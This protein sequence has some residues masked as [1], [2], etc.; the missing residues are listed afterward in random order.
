[1]SEREFWIR[2]LALRYGSAK[3]ARYMLDSQEAGADVLPGIQRLVWLHYDNHCVVSAGILLEQLEQAK[4]IPFLVLPRLVRIPQYLDAL[5]KGETIKG[6]TPVDFLAARVRDA[7]KAVSLARLANN[8][9]INRKSEAGRVLT[10]TE[11][12]LLVAKFYHHKMQAAAAKATGDKG[13]FKALLAISLDDYRNLTNL[14][15]TTYESLSDV[16]AWYPVRFKPDICP[17]HW[18]DILP[19]LEREQAQLW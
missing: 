2:R 1:K 15:R 12:V 8:V 7:E 5:R 6:E 14:T 18:T 16:P 4:G 9:A 10:D 17:Y 3:A 11:A 13:R 19:Y